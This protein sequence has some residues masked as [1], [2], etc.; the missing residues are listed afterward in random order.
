MRKL[1]MYHAIGSKVLTRVILERIKEALDKE[2]TK[3]QNKQGFA[4]TDHTQTTLPPF[5][6]SK[7][8]LLSGSLHFIQHLLTLKKLVT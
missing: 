6:L 1:A 7:S 3:D 2:F 8:S 5:E 4:R